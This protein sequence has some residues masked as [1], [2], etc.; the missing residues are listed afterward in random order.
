MEEIER[1]VKTARLCKG[2]GKNK[3][4]VSL[5]VIARAPLLT[6]CDEP[7]LLLSS[8]GEAMREQG[9]S[10]ASAASAEEKE[11]SGEYKEDLSRGPARLENVLKHSLNIYNYVEEQKKTRQGRI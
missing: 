6:K 2:T 10:E 7:N 1:S 11:S 4:N 8:Y 5:Y 9:A 3:R